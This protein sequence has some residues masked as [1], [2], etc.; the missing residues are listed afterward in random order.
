M[1]PSRSREADKQRTALTCALQ[2]RRSEV[3]DEVSDAGQVLAAKT[4][5]RVTV[6]DFLCE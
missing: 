2:R 1:P 4:V 3:S 5:M 6:C